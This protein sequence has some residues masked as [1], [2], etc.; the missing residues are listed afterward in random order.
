MISAICR[1]SRGFILGGVKATG[2]ELRY[3][4]GL[5]STAL[6]RE[7]RALGFLGK[8]NFHATGA[9]F[10]TD[11]SQK[12][13]QMIYATCRSCSGSNSFRRCEKSRGQIARSI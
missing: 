3:S 4:I 7:S 5:S 8:R 1:S 12:D 2:S 13:E 9:P 10:A 11:C 6:K